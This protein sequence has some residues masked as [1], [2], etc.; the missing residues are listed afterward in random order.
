[1]SHKITADEHT[2]YVLY[3][4]IQPKMY[5]IVLVKLAVYVHTYGNGTVGSEKIILCCVCTAT[6]YILVMNIDMPNNHTKSA[7]GY[8]RKKPS[9]S[10]VCSK[11][12][13]VQKL[14]QKL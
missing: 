9:R 3:Q 8:K 1:M 14:V 7:H 11:Y 2:L 6:E 4:K 12:K 5:T 10:H 13:V